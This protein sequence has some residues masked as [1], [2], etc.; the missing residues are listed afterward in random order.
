MLFGTDSR[1][2]QD[3]S[4]NCWRPTRFASDEGNSLIEVPCKERTAKCSIVSMISGKFLNFKQP[5]RKRLLRDFNLQMLVGRIS[6]L[7]QWSRSNMTRLDRHCIEEGT[8][9]ISVWLKFKFVIFL[10]SIEKS[11]RG[12][13]QRNKCVVYFK[14]N[15]RTLWRDPKHGGR[16]SIAVPHNPMDSKSCGSSGRILICEQNLILK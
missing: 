1:Y 3:V 11:L 14:S 4:K 2:L 16:S 10:G 15:S 5:W 9:L 8:A 12:E 13:E 6:S 7:V